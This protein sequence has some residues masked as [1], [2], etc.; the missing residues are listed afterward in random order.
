MRKRAESTV[1]KI[2]GSELIAQ[3]LVKH[4]I[5]HFFSVPGLGI[6]PLIDAIHAQ[7]DKIRYINGLNETSVALIAEGY[8][9]ATRRP[10]FVNVYHSSGTA[11]SMVAVTVAWADHSPLIITSTTSS[12]KLSRRDQYAAVPRNITEM[13]NQ[14]VKWKVGMQ[15]T[16]PST[17]CCA[18]PPIIILRGTGRQSMACSISR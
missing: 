14:Y 3:S 15:F 18:W 12:R 5:D 8:A 2:S 16:Q 13:T 7:R 6:F 9:R 17:I 4:G 11:L 10:A 1:G